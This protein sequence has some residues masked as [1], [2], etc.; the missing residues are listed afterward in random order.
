MRYQRLIWCQTC[1]KL[2][3]VRFQTVSI[4][5]LIGHFTGKSVTRIPKSSTAQVSTQFVI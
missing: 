5:Y 2:Q 4:V 3:V 1:H